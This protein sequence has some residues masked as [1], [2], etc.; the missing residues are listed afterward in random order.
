MQRRSDATNEER[1]ELLRLCSEHLEPGDSVDPHHRCRRVAEHAARSPGLGRG[2]DR[3]EISDMHSLNAC[4][5]Y[6][7]IEFRKLFHSAS[8]GSSDI[9]ETHDP[10]DGDFERLGCAG[11][12][13]T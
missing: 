7:E 13:V 4:S 10:D 3:G 5:A 11:R 1:T 8:L 9:L 6:V 2:D 12:S